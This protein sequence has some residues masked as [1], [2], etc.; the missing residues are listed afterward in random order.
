M[1]E[2]FKYYIKKREEYSIKLTHLFFP[3]SLPPVLISQTCHCTSKPSPEHTGW[4]TVRTR[5]KTVRP[6]GAY[7]CH[8]GVNNPG[9][10]CIRLISLITCISL[11]GLDTP[12]LIKMMDG[13]I[14][15]CSPLFQICTCLERC[16]LENTWGNKEGRKGAERESREEEEEGSGIQTPQLLQLNHYKNITELYWKVSN[17]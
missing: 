9:S 3:P 12:P 14:R 15:G 13:G 7:S 4:V 16:L 17:C 10:Q 2:F 6:H 8:Y 5:L 11:W 1:Q